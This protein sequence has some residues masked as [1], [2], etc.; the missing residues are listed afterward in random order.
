MLRFFGVCFLTA[1]AAAGQDQPVEPQQD[2]KHIM[3]VIPAQTV[4]NDPHAA[5]LTRARKLRLFIES[6]TDPFSVIG[7]GLQAAVGQAKNEFP[8]Y[9]QGA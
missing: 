3:G 7:V 1:A 2:T 4:T 8:D 6:A 9:G 5:P